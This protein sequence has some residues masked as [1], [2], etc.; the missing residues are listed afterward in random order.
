[1]SELLIK[2]RTEEL[3]VCK[4]CK[5]QHL[6]SFPYGEKY[7][8]SRDIPT[9]RRRF[10]S[11]HFWSDSYN[12]PREYKTTSIFDYD[13]PINYAEAVY[14]VN[15]LVQEKSLNLLVSVIDGLERETKEF[16]S[17]LCN[18]FFMLKVA[19]GLCTYGVA[20]DYLSSMDFVNRTRKQPHYGEDM[21]L[22]K[23]INDSKLLVVQRPPLGEDV[24]GLDMYFHFIVERCTRGLSTIIIH[25][26]INFIDTAPSS[27]CA[28]IDRYFDALSVKGED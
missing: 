17:M 6:C 23:T 4:E 11:D 27:T 15:R 26:D 18:H 7:E 21:P 16:V 19:G 2:K 24:K 1:M 3:Y 10:W 28:L 25:D 9:C 8:T 5:L 14:M 12:V 22:Y 13:D 20:V